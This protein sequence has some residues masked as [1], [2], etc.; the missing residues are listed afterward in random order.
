MSGKRIQV[1]LGPMFL[2]LPE[3]GAPSSSTQA[4]AR[5]EDVIRLKALIDHGGSRPAAQAFDPETGTA[6][7]RSA[8]DLQ[9]TGSRSSFAGMATLDE[10]RVELLTFELGAALQVCHAAHPQPERAVKLAL[11]PAVLRDATLSVAVCDGR[12]E[13]SITVGHADDRE[14]LLQQLPNLALVLGSK[15][16]QRLCLRV[17]APANQDDVLAAEMWPVAQAL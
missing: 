3:A 1:D 9:G 6:A 14:W 2:T 7:M 16:R 17:L 15:L 5:A 10:A 11:R 8:D 12:L 13:F 4:A